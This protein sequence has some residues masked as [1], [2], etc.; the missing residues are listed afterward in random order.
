VL[1]KPVGF[2]SLVIVQ[3]TWPTT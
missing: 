2:D 3:P 1:Y